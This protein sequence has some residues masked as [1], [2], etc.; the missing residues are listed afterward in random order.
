MFKKIVVASDF[1]A[2]ADRA[3]KMATELARRDQGELHV[4]HACRAGSYALPPPLDLVSPMP[5]VA[6]FEHIEDALKVR[7]DRA[8]SEGLPVTTAS[9]VGSPEETIVDYARQAG[10]DLLVIGTS[11]LGAVA[12]ALLGSVAE[13]ILRQAP[14]P[15]LVVPRESA[16]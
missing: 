13:K 14:C 3:L 7:A 1:S 16:R 9:L 10:A 5:A 15:V 11:G 2:N 12:H 6:T 8:R 4:V